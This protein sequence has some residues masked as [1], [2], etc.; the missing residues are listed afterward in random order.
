MSLLI[1]LAAV[2]G[3]FL[4]ILSYTLPVVRNVEDIIPD[5]G[6]AAAEAGTQAGTSGDNSGK[7]KQTSS[8]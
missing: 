4:P 6:A 5:I 1:L 2:I 7:Q 3:L 8:A